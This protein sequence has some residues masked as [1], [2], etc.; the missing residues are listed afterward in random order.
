M[1]CLPNGKAFEN[2]VDAGMKQEGKLGKRALELTP[3]M[4]GVGNASFR[5][6]HSLGK[7]QPDSI[8]SRPNE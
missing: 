5:K 1:L 6:P 7:P 2:A 4:S 3:P 8:G